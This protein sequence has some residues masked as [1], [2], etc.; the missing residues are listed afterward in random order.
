MVRTSTVTISLRLIDLYYRC[1]IRALIVELLKKWGNPRM[2]DASVNTM[3]WIN[4][5][6]N[7]L[8]SIRFDFGVQC[9]VNGP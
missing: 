7:E 3:K 6:L 5:H 4:A 9:S 1:I 2:C 8:V